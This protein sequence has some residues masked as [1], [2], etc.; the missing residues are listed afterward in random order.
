MG[1]LKNLNESGKPPEN[2]LGDANDSQQLFSQLIYRNQIRSKLNAQVQGAIDGNKPLNQASLEK[3]GLGFLTN[4]N[5]RLLEGDVNS[6]QVPFYMLFADVPNYICVR[7]N[8]P[9]Y[10]PVEWE[11]MSQIIEEELTTLLNEWDPFDF[12]MQLG[13]RNGQSFGTGPLFFINKEDFRFEVAP[14][15]TVYVDDE[16][17]QDLSKLNLLYLYYEWTVTELYEAICQEGAEE[18]WDIE[19]VEQI[20]T[21]TCN[22][23]AQTGGWQRARNWVYWQNK[24]RDHDTWFWTIDSKVCTAWGYI[25]EFKKKGDSRGKITRTLIVVDPSTASGKYLYKKTGEFDNWD[26]II[27]PFF[28]EIGNGHW[29]GVKGLGIKAFNARDAQNRLKNRLVDAAMIGAQV[30]LQAKDE[31]ALESFQIGQLGP[32]SV[33]NQE[34]TPAQ[35][36]IASVLDKPMAVSQMLEFDLRSNIGN[37]RQN[38]SN[39]GSVQPVSAEQASITAAYENQLSLG[40][41]TMWLRQLDKLYREM[42][43]RL[44]VEPRKATENYPL[45]EWEEL[46]TAFH[47]RCRDRGVPAAAFKHVKSIKAYRTIGR[48]SEYLKQQQS[49]AVYN[50]FRS[51]PNVPEGVVVKAL[52]GAA[53]SIIGQAAMSMLWPSQ[54]MTMSPTDDASKAQDENAGML[55]AVE[56]IWTPDQNNYAHAATHLQFGIARLQMVSQ[57]QMDP[58]QYLQFAQVALPHVKFTIEKIPGDRK[59]GTAYQAMWNAYQQWEAQTVQLDQ[60]FSAQQQAQAEEQQR[61]QLIQQ[62]A[63]QTGQ[64][65]DPESQLEMARIQSDFELGK[66]KIQADAQ[67]KGAKTQQQ[68]QTNALKTQQ[69]LAKNDL[70]TAQNLNI[71]NAKAS[72]EIQINQAKARSSAKTSSSK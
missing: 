34:L 39:P 71:N 22:T 45:E 44:F 48:G 1:I 60:Q 33:I 52:R 5:W 54:E 51:D 53:A 29:N 62:Q 28:S 30:I 36:P 17:T 50:L 16:V 9:N 61:Q 64:M 21:Q 42:C 47:K 70:M 43:A 20:L 67:L 8:P 25:K 27:H 24:L 32:Y 57:Q 18:F 4:V 68:L 31:K 2:R 13:I 40:Q 69:S 35:F 14:Q 41:Q 10:Q 66:M 3:E 49:V 26:Q 37:L 63:M 38:M 72:S 19:A 7:V 23:A 59:K 15:N 58:A 46:A 12:R 65:M 6:A 55:W 56:P 11:Q